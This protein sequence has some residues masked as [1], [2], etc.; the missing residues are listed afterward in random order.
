[1][2]AWIPVLAV[3]LLVVPAARP[4]QEGR[5][6]EG[7]EEGRRAR[8]EGQP[9]TSSSKQAEA[10]AAAGDMDGAVDAAEAGGG[11]P[12]RPADAS[13]RLGTA[14][15]GQVRAGPR[16]GRLPGRGGQAP[17]PGEGGGAG[18]ALRAAGHAGHGRGRRGRLRRRRRRRPI[19]EGVWPTIALSRHG[20][21]RARPTRRS[22][23]RRRR[24]RR[25][26]TAAATALAYAQEAKGD[27][28]AA[29]ATCRAALGKDPAL[30]APARHRPRARP[31]QDG[32][33]RRGAAAAPKAIENAPGAI[34]AYKESALVEDGPEP[35]QEALGRREHRRRHGRE[36]PEAQALAL[37]VTVGHA[38]STRFR[39]GQVDLAIQ[40]LTALRDQN[41]NVRGGAG[42]AWPRPTWPSVSPMPP[43]VELTK[44]VEL[45]PKDGGGA[46]PARLRAA[47]HE[48]QRGGRGPR[49]RE[50]GGPR[51]RQRDLPHEPRGRARGHEAVRPRGG[52]AQQGHGDARL[53]P[54]RSL[55]LP[56]P[57]PRG[58]KKYKE[59]IRPSRRR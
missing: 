36:G 23:W 26:G 45:D 14:A 17:G 6:E 46:V 30:G 27:L 38:P 34:E 8:R 19:R 44:A 4:G 55:D 41:P 58:A 25:A 31:A 47:R 22:P 11:R 35:P 7:R 52:G 49:L 1:M 2:K 32:P 5:Q 42:G 9:A 24:R 18:A 56:R 57:G 59:A 3:A 13:L 54:G 51:A 43:L 10:K 20:P 15:R 33:R 48:E 39:Q 40:E 50:G 12:T 16:D 28:A 37:E 29:E 21:A 53:Q